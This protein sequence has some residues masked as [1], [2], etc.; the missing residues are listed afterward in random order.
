MHVFIVFYE[1]TICLF[2]LFI[3]L[4]HCMSGAPNQH[5]FNDMNDNSLIEA[6]YILGTGFIGRNLVSHLV[7]HGLVS[8]VSLH[9]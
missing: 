2:N 4:E 5:C 9:K 6:W 8:K 1:K 3:P 7:K